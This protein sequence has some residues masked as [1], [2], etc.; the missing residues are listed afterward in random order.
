MST[1]RHIDL[2]CI[3]VLILTLLLTVLF[4]R[5]EAFGIRVIVD[6]DAE[7]NE[8][9]AYFTAND[10][11]G[12]WTTSGATQI[13]LRG[14]HA[15]VSGGGAYAYNGDVIISGAGKYV[16]SGAL[17]NG[18]ILVDADNSAKI[19]ILLNGAELQSADDACIRVEQADK[20]FLTLAEGTENILRTTAISEE[21]QSSGVDAALFA[22]DDLTLNGSGSLLVESPEAHGIAANDELVI[23]GGTIC[24]SAARD[25]LHANDGIR[26]TSANLDLSASDDGIDLNGSESE[27]YIESGSLHIQAADDGI[28][29]GCSLTI[30]GGNVTVEAGKDGITAAGT[31]TVN[32]GE[33]T[34]SAADDGIHADSSVLISGGTIQIPSCYEGI[35]AVTI[36]ISGGDIAIYPE[37]DGLNANGG[38][39][40][41]GG[42][43]PFGGTPGMHPGDDIPERPDISGSVPPDRPE[44]PAGEMPSRPES[45]EPALPM[46]GSFPNFDGGKSDAEGEASSAS[47]TWIHIR[48]GSITIVN[49]TARDADGIDSNGDIII[50]GG[51]ILVSLVNSGSNSALD[52]GSENGSVM[53]ISGGTVIACGSYAMA[54]GFDSSSTQCAILYG[55]RRG[56]AAGTQ[57][58][59]EDRK[60]NTLLSYEVPCSFSSVALSCSEMQLGETYTLV[61]GDFAEEITL[62]EV[63]AA[64]GD[65]QSEH[66][67]GFMNWGG[68]EFRP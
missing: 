61:I 36:D 20:V 64:F 13:S 44:I 56:A 60:G 40:S 39:F 14:D 67:G 23:T 30:A 27:L 37:D 7:E 65:A 50:S 55:Y 28:A 9:S 6:E 29:A 47:E 25:A 51:T 17:D 43:A 35:E 15:V 33:L 48:G 68:M 46:E 31:V 52:Y 59:L 22:R 49:E 32:G 12:S 34:V 42:G 19:W 8:G 21:Q 18:S 24:V 26:I 10:L 1:N 5:G 54:E 66:F 2:I 58:T 63:S 57:L 16:V 41:F 62:T 45:G 3:I 4:M 53:K 11:N 38:G